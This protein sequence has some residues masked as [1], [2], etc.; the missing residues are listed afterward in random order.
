MVQGDLPDF[1]PRGRNRTRTTIAW[2][3]QGE[4]KGTKP[5]IKTQKEKA[6]VGTAELSDDRL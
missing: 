2:D 6:L 4:E 3:G 5:I 1:L